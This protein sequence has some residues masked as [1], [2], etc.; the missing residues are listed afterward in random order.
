MNGAI[1]A[2][3]GVTETIEI[4]QPS[5]NIFDKDLNTN[6]YLV[7][8]YTRKCDILANRKTFDVYCL[9]SNVFFPSS[10]TSIFVR[11]PGKDNNNINDKND[12]VS[13]F[14]I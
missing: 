2:F 7:I 4:L 5:I 6:A 1:S 9:G 10:Q 14:L 12:F 3:L 13:Y 8:I 11:I